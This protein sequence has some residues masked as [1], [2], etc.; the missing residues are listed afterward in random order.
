MNRITARSNGA[1]E[2]VVVL[3]GGST[4]SDGAAS[5]EACGARMPHGFLNLD[6]EFATGIARFIRGG[7]Y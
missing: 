2:Q 4:G 3:T 1:R 5:L 6:A 7:N